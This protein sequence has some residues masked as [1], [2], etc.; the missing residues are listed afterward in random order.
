MA[1]VNR[2]RNQRRK[3]EKA[4]SLRPANTVI[5]AS[6]GTPPILI[7]SNDGARCRPELSEGSNRPEPIA[8]RL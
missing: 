4:A 6:N 7:A 8:P 5:P 3:Q 1:L 2:G